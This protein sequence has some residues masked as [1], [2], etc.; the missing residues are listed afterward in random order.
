MKMVFQG[1][2]TGWAIL[3]TFVGPRAHANIYE[4]TTDANGNVV[5]SSTVCPGGSGVSAAPG[6]NLTGLDLTQAYLI[7]AN[8]SNADLYNSALTNAN[9]TANLIGNFAG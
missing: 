1:V 8:L 7:S 6:A 4:W 2:V 5:Q 9:L 3:F